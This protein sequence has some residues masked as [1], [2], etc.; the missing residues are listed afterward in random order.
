MDINQ[1]IADNL[2]LVYTLL[3]KFHLTDDQDAES[4]A[5]EA[6]HKAILTFNDANGAKFSTYATCV[7]SNAL[8]MHLRSKNKKRQLQTMSLYEPYGDNFYLV[9]TIGSVD[10]TEDIVCTTLT[11]EEAINAYTRILNS[12]SSAKQRH[13]IE[14]WYNSGFTIKQSELATRVGLTQSMVSRT[15]NGFK[16]RLK[17]ELEEFL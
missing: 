15:I 17:K 6:L 14:L 7:I 5:Y 10:T 11:H 4:F 13:A 16:H 9:D 3:G 2:G 8:R 12:I 1:Q